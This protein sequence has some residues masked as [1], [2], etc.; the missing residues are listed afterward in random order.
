MSLVKWIDFQV[1]G[2]E[3]GSLVA[4]EHERNVPF[5]IRRVYFIYGTAPG[6]SRGYHAHRAL[7][8]V[9]VCMAGSCTMVL[10]DGHHREDVRMDDPSR[11]LLIEGMLWREMHDFSDD[12]VLMVLA[13]EVY[14]EADYI[15]DYQKFASERDRAMRRAKTVRLRLVEPKDA[16]FIYSL[17]TDEKY[18]R[19]LSPVSGDAESQ[20]A[21][22][23]EY[24]HR[25]RANKEFYFI[26]ERMDSG[27]PCGTVRLYDFRG[28]SF[29]W[30][31]WILVEEDKTR[32]AALE[33][34]LMVYDYAFNV[35]GCRRSHFD[36]R[37]ENTKVV[38]YHENMGAVR[39]G[40]DDQDIF[41][42]I[43]QEAVAQARIKFEKLIYKDS[44]QG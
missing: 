26:I 37:K 36:V 2:D 3:R 43:T 29:C 33:S 35:L 13:S 30:G 14:D 38:N 5:D 23:K 20:R 7:R 11:G 9:A 31:S 24:K 42:E 18:N 8:Q 15:R 41:F 19:Y 21:W 39:T 10:D 1:L 34:C 16:E 44:G 22:I 32:T 25:E 6:V 17:R 4:L 12:C 40:E 27:K 28:D